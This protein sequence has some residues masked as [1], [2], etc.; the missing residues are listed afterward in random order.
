MRKKLFVGMFLAVIASMV[1]GEYLF[2]R[3]AAQDA[4]KKADEKQSDGNLFDVLKK[5]L[6]AKKDG[7]PPFVVLPTLPA[8]PTQPAKDTPLTVQPDSSAGI[9][10]PAVKAP[11]PSALVMP[12]PVVVNAPTPQPVPPPLEPMKPLT[13]PTFP[14]A[15]ADP[16]KP[17]VVEPKKSEPTPV[18][19]L[20]FPPMPRDTNVKPAIGSDDPSLSKPK[21]DSVKPKQ[22]SQ[23]DPLWSFSGTGSLTPGA[24]ERVSNKGTQPIAQEVAK[25]KDCPWSLQVEMV[26]GQTIVIATVNKK[27]EF[28]IVCK[29]LDLQTGKG[30]LRAT[31]KVTI[32]GDTFNG[33]CESLAIPLMEDRL[34]LEGGAAVTIQK[35]SANVSE[36]KSAAFELKG[37]T[38]T[39]RI[40]E[41]HAERF[42]QTSLHK[43]IDVNVRQVVGTAPVSD[44]Q[45]T[46]YGTLRRVNTRLQTESGVWQLE[47]RTG[48]VLAT[49]VART[50]GSLSQHEGQTISVYGTA[51]QIDGQRCLRVTHI[52]LP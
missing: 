51:E 12:P 27:H 6:E 9:P 39:L 48:K 19:D 47:D 41:L 40:S 22:I 30:T 14:S 26:D 11:A 7:P 38:L 16:P 35:G 8:L 10:L 31:G 52:A 21:I 5:D 33:T 3:S 15:P 45:W 2:N 17:Q 44:K 28:K 24:T 4:P 23:D 46:P 29:S 25:I 50:G 34:V 49:L 42:L 36:T 13:V 37:E 18:Q 43:A 20:V 1:A 32:T